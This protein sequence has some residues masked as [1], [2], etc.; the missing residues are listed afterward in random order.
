MT[1]EQTYHNTRKSPYIGSIL[2]AIAATTIALTPANAEEG[3]KPET[4]A[5]DEEL[6]TSGS[7]EG[8]IGHNAYGIDFQV[9][10]EL[11]GPF[12]RSAN[13]TGRSILTIDCAGN[14]DPFNIVDLSVDVYKGLGLIAESQF[15]DS[16][17]LRPG[18]MYFNTFDDLLVFGMAT[19]AVQDDTNVELGLLVQYTPRINSR[20][21]L[22][23]S[24]EA[25]SNFDKD[26]H[27]FSVQWFRLGVKSGELSKFGELSYGLAANFAQYG[28]NPDTECNGGFFTR[29]SF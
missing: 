16:Y 10:R 25:F 15:T 20:Y 6:V 26:D 29:L 14:V 27:N 21:S 1:N 23:S 24:L 28:N 2:A 13:I 3:D 18:V 5:N 11:N 22:F 9:A 4:D 17:L 19:G 12:G 8:V 7:F